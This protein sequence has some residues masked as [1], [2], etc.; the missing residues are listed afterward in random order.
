M[1]EVE[2]YKVFGLM[3]D[4]R[5]KVATNNAMPGWAFAFIKLEYVLDCSWVRGKEQGV[6]FS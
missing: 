4:K 3:S 1:T 5:A 6:R 2:V